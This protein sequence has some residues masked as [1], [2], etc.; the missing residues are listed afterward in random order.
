MALSYLLLCHI[1]VLLQQQVVAIEFTVVGVQVL[2]FPG[3]TPIWATRRTLRYSAV[4]T[5]AGLGATRKHAK[6]I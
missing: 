6:K 4:G 5:E 1:L 2:V 3:V